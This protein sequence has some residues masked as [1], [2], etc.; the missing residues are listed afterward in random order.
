[1]TRGVPEEGALCSPEDARQM[2]KTAEVARLL[3]T[4]HTTV[5]RWVREHGLPCYRRPGPKG[6]GVNYLFRWPEV[7][8]WLVKEGGKTDGSGT[9]E[10]DV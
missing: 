4:N 2:M 9:D 7:E 6:R 3:D 8:A 1:M 10:D 5:L